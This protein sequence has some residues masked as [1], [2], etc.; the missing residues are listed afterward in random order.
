MQT[1][2][3]WGLSLRKKNS[4]M[5]TED[6]GVDPKGFMQVQNMYLRTSNG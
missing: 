5:L 6:V 1:K 4:E 2:K 3:F